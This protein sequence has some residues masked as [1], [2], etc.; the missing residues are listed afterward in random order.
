MKQITK[1]VYQIP[2]M[3][4]NAINCYLVGDV[5][6]DAG[7]KSSHTKIFPALKG[8]T[9]TAHALTHAHADHQ[10]SSKVI[11]EALNIP[12]WCSELEKPQAE[13]GNV[14][15]EYPKQ[16]H[17]ITKFQK[18]YWAGNGYKVSRILKEGDEVNGFKVIDTPGHSSGHISFFREKDGVLIVGDAMVNMN[19]LTTAV[20]LHQPPGLFTTDK[21]Q[22][23]RSIHKLAALDPAILCFGHGP[24]LFN[25]GEIKAFVRGIKIE[26]QEVIDHNRVFA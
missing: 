8:R 5:L 19:L 20:G 6:I 18:N 22:N 23:I 21:Q 14:T 16:E 25:R 24:V 4:R 1:D 9:I 2:L 10:G 7:I 17:I 3:P 26:A 15:I 11:C 13:S 12:L